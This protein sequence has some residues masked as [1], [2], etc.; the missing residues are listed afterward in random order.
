MHNARIEPQRSMACANTHYSWFS[1]AGIYFCE[2]DGIIMTPDR[3]QAT[4]HQMRLVVTQLSHHQLSFQPSPSLT[5]ATANYHQHPPIVHW[6]PLS[7][8]T[9]KLPGKSH[10]PPLLT[11]NH[12]STGCRCHI[13]Q[14]DKWPPQPP[15]HQAGRVTTATTTT[16]NVMYK[17]L[18]TT[19]QPSTPGHCHVTNADRPQKPQWQCPGSQHPPTATIDEL[20]PPRTQPNGHNEKGQ[21]NEESRTRMLMRN[22]RARAQVS[23]PAPLHPPWNTDQHNKH[24][25]HTSQVSHPTHPSLASWTPNQTGCSCHVTGVDKHPAPATSLTYCHITRFDKRQPAQ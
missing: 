21:R 18:T 1:H 13:T 24:P 2:I 9:T 4:A 6:Y 10:S 12:D 23:P 16:T 7:S 11:E 22:P 25:L 15:R 17:T 19:T 8:T 20:P 5:T 3:L 14:L